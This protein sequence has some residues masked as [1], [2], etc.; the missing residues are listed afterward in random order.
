MS[1]VSYTPIALDEER[2]TKAEITEDFDAFI[3]FVKTTHPDLGYSADL[4]A[5]DAATEQ[6]R[7]NLH[8][9]ATIR[10]A[11][12]LM[13]LVN[14]VFGDAHIGLRRPVEALAAYEAEG[15]ALFPAPVVFDS[16]GR[17]RI[18]PSVSQD[19]GFVAG[20][21]ILS[22]NGVLS[23]DIITTLTPRMRGESEALRK[24]ILE[25]YFPQYFWIAYGGFE[26]YAVRVRR[27]GRIKV[28]QPEFHASGEHNDGDE[29]F[30]YETLDANTGY[31]N[32]KTFN[33]EYKDQ[34]AEF[35]S[36]AFV[37]IQNAGVK[38]LVIDLRENG[39]GAH[40]VSDL[41]MSYL[42]ED[43]YSPIS[44]VTARITE[45][46]VNRIP[47]AKLGDVVTV[48]FQL[49]VTPPKDNPLRFMG[50]VYAMVG[51]LTYSQA[52]AFAS[53]LQDFEIA[54][55][56]G[57]ETEGPANQTG[58][59]QIQVLPNTGIQA[60]APIY[61]F[62]RANGDTSRRGVIPDIVIENDP[63]D[64]MHSVRALLTLLQPP[65]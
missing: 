57:E 42:T 58:Q 39:G 52:I 56:A 60:L 23:T 16:E 22:I 44:R 24:L 10:E 15:G 61:I 65:N 62:T 6:I 41:L 30:S 4:A 38:N 27:G 49:P 29:M 17:L 43:A 46:N 40:D 28:V 12:M 7:E 54:V 25:L 35:I 31:L 9:N 33:I 55:I 47:G 2:F 53:T 51:A 37:E 34:F 1:C 21:E 63:L 50:N 64:P 3:E 8:E 45:E 11:W 13:A 14:P 48:P 18:A 32:V 5:L 59:V 26:D 36:D 19:L 20:D